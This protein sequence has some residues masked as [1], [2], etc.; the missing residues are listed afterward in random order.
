VNELQIFKVLKLGIPKTDPSPCC[1]ESL[2][3]RLK[4]LWVGF[5]TWLLLQQVTLSPKGP[6]SFKR[7]I[8]NLG[9]LCRSQY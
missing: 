8:K 3:F 7:T 5:A 6:L 2:Q 4:F 9:T 1:L